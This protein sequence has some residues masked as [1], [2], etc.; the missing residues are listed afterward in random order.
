M[1]EKKKKNPAYHAQEHRH[2]IGPLTNI[3]KLPVS[4]I[5]HFLSS[6]INYTSPTSSSMVIFQNQHASKCFLRYLKTVCNAVHAVMQLSGV[7]AHGSRSVSD[8]K[9]EGG[10]M[11][12]ALKKPAVSKAPLA[13]A[14]NAQRYCIKTRLRVL[15]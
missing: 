13:E 9:T 14:S 3:V 7:E 10:S 5:F 11:K 8:S 2:L 6:V 12:G 4:I 15:T 1:E